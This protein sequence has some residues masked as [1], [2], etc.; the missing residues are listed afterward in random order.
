MRYAGVSSELLYEAVGVFDVF[1]ITA[2]EMVPPT[3]TLAEITSRTRRPVIIGAFQ[4]GALDRGLPS[5]GLRAV[6]SQN[7]RGIAYRH[8]VE[9]AAANPNL[10]GVHYSV[11][12]DQP[13]LGRVDGENY[14][15]GF[16]DVCHR[17]YEEIV[18]SARRAHRS[19]Y[20]VRLGRDKPY[21]GRALEVP[22]VVRL[23]GPPGGRRTPGQART[24]AL[25]K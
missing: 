25:R 15:I 8:Y 14:Q 5:T 13:L 21:V 24:T 16:V 11:L 17:P 3:K 7:E 22:A 9:R 10:V 12:N 1:S 19:V 2:Y 18:D 6:E 23:L 20:A 4:F